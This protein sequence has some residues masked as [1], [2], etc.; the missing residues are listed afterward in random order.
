MVVS[1]LGT[2]LAPYILLI[3]PYAP[4]LFG[5]SALL[6]GISSLILPETLGRPLPESIE[7]GEKIGLAWLYAKKQ[8]VIQN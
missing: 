7:D 3:G 1:R 6:A 4:L 5:F 8:S 2:I